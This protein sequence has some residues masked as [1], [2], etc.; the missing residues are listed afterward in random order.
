MTRN[1]PN[2]DPLLRNSLLVATGATLAILGAAACSSDDDAT[3]SAPGVA[4]QELVIGRYDLEHESRGVQLPHS[5]S[6]EQQFSDQERNAAL[7]SFI[8]DQA[9]RLYVAMDK[10]DLPGISIKS[11]NTSESDKDESR[12][13]TVVISLQTHSHFYDITVSGRKAWDGQSFITHDDGEVTIQPDSIEVD[14]GPVDKEGKRMH[15]EGERVSYELYFVDAH[16]T[17]DSSGFA[18]HFKERGTERVDSLGNVLGDRRGHVVYDNASISQDVTPMG[19]QVSS[20][21]RYS[22]SV[23]AIDEITMNGIE[24]VIDEIVDLH[25]KNVEQE[26]IESSALNQQSSKTSG[27]QDEESWQTTNTILDE[28]GDTVEGGSNG[29]SD[30]GTNGTDTGP[31][32][33]DVEDE[34][35][36][37]STTLAD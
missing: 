18:A 17:T 19:S 31:G 36:H 8:H 24:S 11:Y 5:F 21:E 35:H 27:Y 20:R 6:Y 13:G 26:S 33:P 28:D 25:R 32:M 10:E 12:T 37:P 14:R 3:F 34:S 9:D 16:S 7:E 22:A 29:V 23:A 30:S 15:N 1:N 2:R 4:E